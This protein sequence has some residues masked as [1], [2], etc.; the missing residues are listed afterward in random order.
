[1]AGDTTTTVE[2]MENRLSSSRS[3]LLAVDEPLQICRNG[4][5]LSMTMRTP[6][7]DLGLAVGFLSTEAIIKDVSQ[8]PS[9]RAEPSVSS[10]AGFEL[11]QNSVMA[12]IPVL[13]AVGAP[14]SLAVEMAKR[15]GIT[16]VGFLCGRRFNVYSGNWR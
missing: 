3:D 5:P 9:M 10:R 11:V 1:M 4:S 6:G 16:L 8:I 12:A 7:S 15:F 2:T 14:S 13:A